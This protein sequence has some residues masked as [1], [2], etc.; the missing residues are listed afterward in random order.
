VTRRA[1]ERSLTVASRQVGL[2]GGDR[3]LADATGHV[4]GAGDSYA[5]KGR[6]LKLAPRICWSLALSQV[7]RMEA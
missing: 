2:V 6:G 5:R 3:S 4:L 1:G 7:L